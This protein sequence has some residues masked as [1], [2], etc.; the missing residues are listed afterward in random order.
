MQ[1]HILSLKRRNASFGEPAPA[2]LNFRV[3][4]AEAESRP[5]AYGQDRRFRF[6]RNA[7]RCGSTLPKGPLG[8]AD[9]PI[10]WAEAAEPLSC[11]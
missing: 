9:L 11:C 8:A 3:C 10:G 7:D 1:L 2:D 5:S 6:A 4:Y